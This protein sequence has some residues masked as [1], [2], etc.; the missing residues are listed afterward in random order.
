MLTKLNL[1]QNWSE[2][3]HAN[4]LRERLPRRISPEPHLAL[5]AL[6]F[7]LKPMPLLSFLPL[8]YRSF[9]TTTTT[10]LPSLLLVGGTTITVAFGLKI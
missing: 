4:R 6:P 2:L 1:K 8:L 3:G 9:C 5:H 7:F 10:P